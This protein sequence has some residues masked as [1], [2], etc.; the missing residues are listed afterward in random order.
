MD[1]WRGWKS[2]VSKNALQYRGNS[3]HDAQEFLLWLL[4]RVHEDL[5]HAIKES[6]QS[7]LKLPSETD[8]MPEGP[9]FPVCSTFVQE[10]FQAQY[11]SSFDMA[12]LSETEQ[13]F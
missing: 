11:R 4:D 8:M 2:I 12:S 3:Q 10:L 6:G 1:G 7:P 13:H 9:S 5:N